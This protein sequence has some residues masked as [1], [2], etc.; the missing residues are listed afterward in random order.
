MSSEE[1]VFKGCQDGV[2]VSDLI[3]KT[4]IKFTNGLRENGLICINPSGKI[5]LTSRGKVARRMGLSNYLNLNEQER[6][7]LNKDVSEMESE[8]IG[9]MVVF[10]SLLLSL[11]VIVGYW[12]L[13]I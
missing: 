8:N 6:N 4:S 11:L 9:L 12:Y 5:K 3:K 10:G 2:P 1:R 7:F 13:H